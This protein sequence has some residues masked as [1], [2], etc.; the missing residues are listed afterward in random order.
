M[1]TRQSSKNGTVRVVLYL[2]MSSAKQDKSIPAQRDELT[3]QIEK[4]PNHRIVGEYIDEAISGDDTE[5]RTGF[6]QMRRDADAGEF[7]LVLCWDQ[8][9]FG[10]FDQLDAGYWIYPFRQAGVRLETIAQ[11]AIDWEDLTGQLVYSV[12]QMGKAQFLRDLSRNTCRGMLSSAREGR[13]GTGGPSPYGYRSKNGEVQVIPEE[14]EVVRWIFAEYLKSE[15][16]LRGLAAALNRRKTSPPRG[17][18]WRDSS[19]RAILARRKY[20]GTFV[21]GERNSGR[22][23]SMKDGEVIPRRKTEKNTHAEPIVHKDKFEAIIDQATFDKV[24]ARLASRKTNTAPRSARQYLLSG[25]V[26]CGDCG[27]AMGGIPQS[28]GLAYKCRTYHQSGATAC[29]CNTIAEAPLV[30][31]IVGKVQDRYLSDDALARLRRAIEKAQNRSK[32]RPRDLDRLRR[33]IDSLD[34][35][36]DRGAERVLNAPADLLPMIY[37]K[38]E[39]ARAQRDRLKAELDA[40]TSREVRSNGKDGSE[41][42]QAINALR[43]LGEALSKASPTDT[44][45]LLSQ[46]VTRI[47]LHFEDNTT[48]RQKR[49]FSH[50]TIHIRPDA[51]ESQGTQP[52]PEVSLL[53]KKGP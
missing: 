13:A 45:K 26:R 19:V 28:S 51:G 48:G 18:V 17:K 7:D 1:A 29:H 32:P 49:A 2:R 52:F 50:G 23:F 20:T 24:Q 14:A 6:L 22:Y 39:E 31:V 34:K 4:R 10:R 9:R 37:R 53:R 21:Y 35:K 8:D 11:G 47:E 30:A 44:K 16:S 36:I 46:I 5:R 42:D 41:I 40:L 3:R 25:L 15:S 33:E 27:G 12:N 43:D 38:L